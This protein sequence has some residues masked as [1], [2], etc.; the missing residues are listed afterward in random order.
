M[1]GRLGR[2]EPAF[3]VMLYVT[4]FGLVLMLVPGLLDWR[5]IDTKALALCLAL[6]PLGLLGKYCTIRR[7]R[8][9]PL[10][11]VAPVDYCWLLSATL[12]V[13]AILMAGG[14]LL[15]RLKYRPT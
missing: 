14:V 2:S 13:C 1:I 15:S 6:G 10:S 5:P 12:T 3:T 8:S 11:V 4:S 9:V 7:Y